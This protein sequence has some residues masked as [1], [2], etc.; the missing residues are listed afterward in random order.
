MNESARPEHCKRRWQNTNMAMSS[1]SHYKANPLKR[2]S[3][4]PISKVKWTQSGKVQKEVAV[5]LDK[6]GEVYQ[7]WEKKAFSELRNISITSK[8]HAFWALVM[9][10][11]LYGAETWAVTQQDIQKLKTFQMRILRD[12]LGVTR[13]NILQNTV[14]LE[15]TGELPVEDQ[16]RQRH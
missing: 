7:M 13:L 16:L 1:P 5:R 12:I 15:R 14:I 2:C 9:S 3:P 4:F 6:V 8:M 11:L 10:V